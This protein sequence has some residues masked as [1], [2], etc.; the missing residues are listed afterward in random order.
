MDGKL[1]GIGGVIA[2]FSAV[3][4]AIL[5]SFMPGLGFSFKGLTISL[6]IGIVIM[7]IGWRKK[8]SAYSYL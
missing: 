6:I 8:P 1:F 3:F 4:I 5:N 2:G 7:I